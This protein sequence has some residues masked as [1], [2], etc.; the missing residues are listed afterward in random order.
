MFTALNADSQQV[1]LHSSSKTLTARTQEEEIFVCL[2]TWA[3]INFPPMALG[4]WNLPHW[5]TRFFHS[6]G[7]ASE[8]EPT[9]GWVTDT[10]YQAISVY[11]SQS[12]ENSDVH[13]QSLAR[14]GEIVLVLVTLSD[15]ARSSYL[16]CG[17]FCQEW[18]KFQGWNSCFI[19]QRLHL[20]QPLVCCALIL[21]SLCCM[22]S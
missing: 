21:C 5:L 14:P 7:V 3:N 2:C 13:C 16:V 17:C 4:N 6:C 8:I 9:S 10:K 18:N 22:Q 1:V 12:S 20:S 19:S 11:C 15:R